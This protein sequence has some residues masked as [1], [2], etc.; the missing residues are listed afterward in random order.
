M[1]DDI[2]EYHLYATRQMGLITKKISG[3]QGQRNDLELRSDDERSRTETLAY[4]GI[5][6]RKAAEAEKLAAV[7]E[8]KFAAIIAEKRES[9][10]LTKHP[11]KNKIAESN[12][13]TG[14]Y[15]ASAILKKGEPCK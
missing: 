4:A 15:R 7:P 2:A 8:D 5:D 6:R 3:R 9:G 12:T 1:K 14:E 13:P 11:L 10:E